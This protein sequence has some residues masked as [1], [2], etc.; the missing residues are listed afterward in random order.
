MNIP[1]I[2]TTFLVDFLSGLL[3]TPSPTGFTERAVAFTEQALG[4]CPE[5]QFQRTRKGALLV[6]FPGQ[7]SNAPRGLTAHIDTLGAMVKEV[8]SN[9]RLKLTKIGGYAWNTVEGEGVR[10]F[11]RKNGVVRGSLLLAKSS[12]HVHGGV[13]NEAKRDDEAMEVRLD[14]VTSSADETRALGIGVG[15]FVAFD[16]RVEMVNGFVRSRHLDDKACVACILAAFKALHDAGL[17]PVQTV[18][19]LISNYEEVGHGAS[20]GFPADLAELL[21]VDMAAIGDG[22]TSDEFHATLCV[23]DSG[24]PYH[25]GMSQR[26]R[27]LAEENGIAHKVDIYPFYGSDGEAYWRAGGDVPVALIGPGVDASHSYERTHLDA[28]VATTQWVLAYLLS[29]P[30]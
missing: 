5:V 2:D 25:H 17:K 24:G 16:P 10:V 23:K 26:M 22:Q 19:A 30:L 3:N 6:T 15:D 18:Y 21:A 7:K 1:V 29:T 28:L 11:S 20:A 14:V 4:V 27:D 13:V 8:K 9:G 12:S